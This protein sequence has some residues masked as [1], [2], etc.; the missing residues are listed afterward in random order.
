M[1]RDGVGW[2]FS[3]LEDRGSNTA[4]KNIHKQITLSVL[5]PQAT[6]VLL[7]MQ[8][9][10][11]TVVSINFLLKIVL[12]PLGKRFIIGPFLFNPD[13]KLTKLV[14]SWISNIDMDIFRIRSNRNNIFVVI[15]EEEIVIIFR[16]VMQSILW[17]FNYFR[18]GRILLQINI[19]RSVDLIFRPIQCD[20]GNWNRVSNMLQK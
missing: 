6:R 17:S 14:I 19:T 11:Y 8:S 15:S 13:I 18:V 3:N 5:I 10:N 1:W 7:F 20:I 16:I 12:V 9:I 4:D 2:K